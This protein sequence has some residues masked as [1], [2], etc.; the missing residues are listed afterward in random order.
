MTKH[1]RN[2]I[3]EKGS[4]MSVRTTLMIIFF[5]FLGCS[6]DNSTT[7]GSYK[8]LN[9]GGE[10]I[11]ETYPDGSSIQLCSIKRSYIFDDGEQEFTE[12]CD[13]ENYYYDTCDIDAVDDKSSDETVTASRSVSTMFH[14][15]VYNIMGNI[16]NTGYAHN[17][18]NN[19]SLVPNYPEA[20]TTHDRYDLFLDCSGFVGYYVVQ[21]IA[22]KLYNDVSP[23]DYICQKRP[24]AADFAD[25]IKNAPEVSDDTPEATTEDLENGEVCWG[26]VKHLRNAKPGDILVYKHPKNIKD[27]NIFCKDHDTNSTRSIHT[28]SGN[29]GHI[30]FIMDIPKLSNRCKDNSFSCGKKQHVLPGDWQYVVKVADSTTSRHMSDSRVHG[31]DRSDFEGHFYHA[32]AINETNTTTQTKRSGIVKKC[33]DGSYSKNCTHALKDINITTKHKTNPT[34]IGVGKMY[35]NADRHGYRNNYTSKIV[36]NDEE[37]IVFIGRPVKCP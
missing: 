13:L 24:L 27:K 10:I 32:W 2:I 23:S 11:T 26:Q 18:H 22:P 21:G 20:N 34:G 37:Q 17:A 25:A 33:D 7:L 5:L 9:D 15:Q 28:V 14:D 36:K 29:T 35:V 8:C 12:Q 4:V 6:S 3:W 1:K 31:K 16:E 30:L 19:F